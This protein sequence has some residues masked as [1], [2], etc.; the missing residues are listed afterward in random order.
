MD[1]ITQSLLNEFSDSFDLTELS[2]DKRF[3]HFASYIA[4]R[5]K[6][7]ETFE[8]MDIV[9][10]SGADTGIDA[11]AIIVNGSLITDVDSF[12]EIAK[13]TSN[14]DVSF[15]FIQA[16][17]TS[18]FDSA[19]I[20][21]FGF[22]VLDF[23]KPEPTLPRNEDIQNSSDV[24]SAIYDHS[25]KFKRSR[26][27]CDLYYITTGTWTGD[28]QLIARRDAVI[29]DLK[30]SGLFSEIEFSCVGADGVARLYAQ[31]KNAISRT[32]QF[33]N[34]VE[35]P[36]ME[37]VKEAFLGYLP[38]KEFVELVKSDEEEDILS[39]IFYDNVRDWQEYNKVNDEIR[40]TL[41]SDN[42]HRF[43]LMNN[44][45]TIIAR[46][47]QRVGSKF[48]IEDFQIVNGCQTSHVLFDQSDDIDTNVC[49]PLRLIVTQDEGVIED[50]IRATNRQTQLREEQ[51]IALMDF[52]KKLETFFQSFPVGT[53]LYYER[54][55]NQYSRIDIEK[56]RIVTPPNLIRSYASIYLLEP[57]R[58]TR[59]FK[60]ILNRVGK[61]I[62]VEN[63]KIDQYYSSAYAFYKL[64]YLFRSQKLDAKYKPARFHILMAARMLF[65]PK[66]V[67][68]PNSNEAAKRSVAFAEHLTDPKKADALFTRAADAV[69]KVAKGNFHR[70][71]IRTQPFTEQVIAQCRGP[72]KK[73]G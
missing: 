24:M 53:R 37:G 71:N 62:F 49:V 31:T 60:S 39:T 56:T 21:S 4:V 57:H 52:S 35:L 15:I 32:I 9:V 70:D 1:R 14:L 43:V 69:S 16:E 26:P 66:P 64:E 13:S 3:E 10:G 42:S 25:S 47:L 17:R 33:A 8:T 45:I 11:V 29:D 5:R 73:G 30:S 23:F 7:S 61:D 58:T 38:I 6:H 55:S 63:H 46:D 67:P 68:L 54:R 20:G 28:K 41:V 59:D 40:E 50:I 48:S 2:E 65:D 18:S 36:E 22:G 19:K 27:T 34:R 12:N 72:T 44:G 51:F